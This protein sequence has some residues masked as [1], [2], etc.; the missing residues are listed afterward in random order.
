MRR[1]ASRHR[2]QSVKSRAAPAKPDQW[3][4]E[5]FD[6][7]NLKEAKAPLDELT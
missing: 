1:S 7:A 6:S 2:L 4:T 3:F 5:G